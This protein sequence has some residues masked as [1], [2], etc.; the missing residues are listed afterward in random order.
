M[1]N[2]QA[3]TVPAPTTDRV[4]FQNGVWVIRD[5]ITGAAYGPFGL[6]KQADDALARGKQVGTRGVGDSSR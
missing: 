6:K 1:R 2:T 5:F 3:K 4:V